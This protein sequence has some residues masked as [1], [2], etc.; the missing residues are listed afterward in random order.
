MKPP[1]PQPGKASQRP[2]LRQRTMNVWAISD[3]HLSFASRRAGALR[4][5]LAG[6]CPAD[7]GALARTRAGRRPGAHSRRSLDGAEPP[8]PPARSGLAG[9]PAGDQGGFAGEPRP[10]VERCC[11]NP[12]DAPRDDAGRR[13]RRPGLRGNGRLR[14]VGPHRR[15]SRIRPA[16]R[17][18]SAAPSK[19]SSSLWIRQSGSG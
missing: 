11:E 5:A 14:G 1:T 9:S 3:L 13:R 16:N 6:S 17:P 4:G 12:P 15:Q 7:R 2:V 19:R 8:R 18:R 10:V